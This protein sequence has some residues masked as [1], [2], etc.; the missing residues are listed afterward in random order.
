MRITAESRIREYCKRYPDA[1]TSLHAF[2]KVARKAQWRHIQD[3]R[4]TYPTADA[5]RVG[6]GRTVTVIN[7]RKNAYRLIVAL[8]YNVERM[9]VLRFLRHEEYSEG[10]WKDQL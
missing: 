1:A 5:V 4:A 10:S 3:L 7:I 6:S 8:H 9:Y 2:L